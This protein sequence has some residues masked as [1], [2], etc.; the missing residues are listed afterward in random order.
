MTKESQITQLEKRAR[1][2]RRIISSLND[3]PMYGIN[4][5][6]DKILH[7]KIDALKDHLKLKITRNN[8][9]KKK[10]MPNENILILLEG[11]IGDVILG[12]SMLKDFHKKFK[13][14][15]AEV[16]YRLVNLCR[17]SFPE[18][19]FY[20]VRESR[21]AELLFKHDLSLFDKGIYWGSIGSYV[22]EKILDFPREKRVYLNIDNNKVYE[23]S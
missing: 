4:E 5:H 18:I 21:N 12:L 15:S 23:I 2:F 16:D 6:L 9:D 14:I 17:R 10:L 13:K 1:G 11:G 8:L 20:E 19:D 7:V 22:R 3:L